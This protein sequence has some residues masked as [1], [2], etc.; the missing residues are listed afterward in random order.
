MKRAKFAVLLWP[1]VLLS[2]CASGSGS[3]VVEPAATSAPAPSTVAPTSTP[4]SST[5]DL[6]A[7]ALSSLPPLSG[8]Y[9]YLELAAG[10]D[11]VK[12]PKIPSQPPIRGFTVVGVAKGT[13]PPAV[14][15]LEV[16]RFDPGLASS[17]VL[18]Q[19]ATDEA[20]TLGGGDPGKAGT[21]D[22][23]AVRTVSQIQ[24]MGV[25]GVVFRRGADVVIVFAPEPA[26][27]AGITKAFI[28][29]S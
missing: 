25:T 24:G 21:T 5:A 1:L 2:G 6:P 29:G 7:L 8:G 19:V 20:K 22:G 4:T 11:P 14:A 13:T 16:L 15:S 12:P 23:V 18:D 17:P 3:A 10:D 26:D 9:S 28:A 27:A